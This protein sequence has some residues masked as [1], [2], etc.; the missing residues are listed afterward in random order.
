[1]T[2]SAADRRTIEWLDQF[3]IQRGWLRDDETADPCWLY[4]LAFRGE[5][6]Q[7]D[8]AHLEQPDLAAFGPFRPSLY[9]TRGSV[10]VFTHGTWNGCLAH[11]ERRYTVRMADADFT[12]ELGRRVAVVERTSVSE[13]PAPFHRCLRFGPCGDWFRQW[14][15]QGGSWRSAGPTV[16]RPP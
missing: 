3:L 16:A 15:Q 2:S 9:L 7:Q 10:V 14:K 8:P 5:D 1:M 13:N 12:A 11:R 4:P 6:I